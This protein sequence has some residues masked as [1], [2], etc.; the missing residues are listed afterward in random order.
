[1]GSPLLG[2][3]LDRKFKKNT[4]LGMWL[5]VT[6]SSISMALFAMTARL[7]FLHNALFMFIAG[8]TNGGADSLLGSARTKINYG[9][10]LLKICLSHSRICFNENGRGKWND[11][12]CCTDWYIYIYIIRL[13]VFKFHHNAWNTL[14][15]YVCR[16]DKWGWNNGRSFGR[17]VLIIVIMINSVI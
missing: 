10:Y 1:M 11:V 5:C 16:T 9:Y 4:L 7:G 6:V 12:R 8:A 13:L 14:T 3:I 15:C 17:C 2:L